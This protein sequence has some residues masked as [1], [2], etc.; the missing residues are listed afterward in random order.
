LFVFAHYF[1][2]ICVICFDSGNG[3]AT[4]YYD[5]LAALPRLE[6]QR[7]LICHALPRV[8]ARSRKACSA[9]EALRAGLLLTSSGSIFG[10]VVAPI[11]MGLGIAA[12]VSAMLLPMRTLVYGAAGSA[13]CCFLLGLAIAIQIIAP[14]AA[15]CCIGRSCSPA[16]RLRLRRYWILRCKVAGSCRHCCNRRAWRS[17]DPDDRACSPFRGGRRTPQAMA[18]ILLL[19]ALLAWPLVQRAAAARAYAVRRWCCWSVQGG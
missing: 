16:L 19:V 4:N 18:L 13:S 1:V 8:L 15:R 2:A 7:F 17:A 5:R 6:R 14:T 12:A 9:T 10:G 11:L 3:G